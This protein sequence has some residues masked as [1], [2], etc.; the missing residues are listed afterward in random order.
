MVNSIKGGLHVPLLLAVFLISCS[1][2]RIWGFLR[3][4]R[5]LVET[6]FRLD[7]CVGRVAQ[8]FRDSLNSLEISNQRITKLRAAIQMAE[9]EP[10]LIPPLQA[11][12]MAQVTK[13]ELIRAGWDLKRGHWLIS[14]GCGNPKDTA[15]PLPGFK[16]IRNPPDWVGPQ[17]LTWE[18]IMPDK[19]E[20]QVGHPPR[21]AA[22]KVEGGWDEKTGR[23]QWKAIWSAPHKLSW[24]SFP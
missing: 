5:F 2:F 6:Q 9:L 22:A 15:H 10:W 1:G 4:W 16:F 17:A 3:N 8:E 24:A 14:I 11:I 20:F 18:E 13:Q 23:N 19:F 12:L 21:Y 7:R